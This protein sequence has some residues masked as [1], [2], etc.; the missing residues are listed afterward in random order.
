MAQQTEGKGT[1]TNQARLNEKATAGRLNKRH[2]AAVKGRERQIEK[3]VPV[4]S[5][6]HH[7]KNIALCSDVSVR[8]IDR[9]GERRMIRTDEAYVRELLI[10]QPAVI[11]RMGKQEFLVFVLD[12]RVTQDD[13]AF[14]LTQ[15]FKFAAQKA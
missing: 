2:R 10:G 7:G 6:T 13:L 9:H 12:D 1:P 8:V 4:A 14:L 3:V 15:E 5:A 11:E